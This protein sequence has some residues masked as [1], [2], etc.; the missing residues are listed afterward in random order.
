MVSARGSRDP[1]YCTALGKATA[2]QLPEARVRKLLRG[3]EMPQRTPAIITSLDRFLAELDLVRRQGRAVD[4]RENEDDGRCVAVGIP[5]SRIPAALSLSV[6]A[7]RF[8]LKDIP[9]VA[10]TL[11]CAAERFIS[12]PAR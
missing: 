9:R 1:L 6:P 7:S 5:D 2:A 3:V 12:D 8:P 4:D 11:T 10:R